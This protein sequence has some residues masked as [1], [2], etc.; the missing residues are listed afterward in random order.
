LILSGHP[1]WAPI[2]YQEDNKIVGA[3]PEIAKKIFEELG[4]EATSSYEDSWDVVQEKT[5][6]G[7]IDLLVA[8]Y[9]TEERESY[10]DYSSPYT[11]DPVVLIMKKGK[12]FDYKEWDD[13]IVKKGVITSGDS[14]GEEFDNFIKK[15]LTVEMIDTP[16]EVFD[17]LEKEEVDYFVYALYSAKDYMF[18]NDV[19]DSLI[20]FKEFL[21]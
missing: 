21:I 2:M 11:I 3:G 19:A 18:Q 6:N 14:Y 9:K 17:L 1:Q 12:V 5:K 15:S 20:D 4:V 7:E 10:M 8:A 13:L 16:K